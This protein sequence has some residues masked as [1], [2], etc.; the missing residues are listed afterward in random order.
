ME[1]LEKSSMLYPLSIILLAA[2]DSR[3]FQGNKMLEEIGGKPMFYHIVEKVFGIPVLNRI[4]VTQYDEITQFLKT[5]EKEEQIVIVKNNHSD[6]GISYSIQLGIYEAIGYNSKKID[7]SFE[8]QAFLFAVC[9][10]PWITQESIMRLITDYFKSDK[11]IACLSY[12]GKSGNPVIFHKKYMEELLA[13]KG[14]IGGRAVLKKHLEDVEF[15]EVT[16]PL[17]LSDIDTRDSLG[18]QNT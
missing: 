7:S 15:I 10:Q 18:K 11:S 2:G 3:R 8:P 14:D 13:L 6:L 5:M 12:Q 17:E 4:L 16:K 1:N 9:D